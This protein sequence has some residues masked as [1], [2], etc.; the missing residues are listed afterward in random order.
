MG[1]FKVIINSDNVE[2][3]PIVL[4]FPTME[5]KELFPVSKSFDSVDL[6]NTLAKAIRQSRESLAGTKNEAAITD[7]CE[8]CTEASFLIV[9]RSLSGKKIQYTVSKSEDY[10]PEKTKIF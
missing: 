5:T 1:S 3:G 10:I 4:L 9:R 8:S 7:V 2:H 6:I